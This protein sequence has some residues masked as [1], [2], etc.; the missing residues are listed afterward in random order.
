MR[1]GSTIRPGAAG[2]TECLV[3]VP[4]WN[5]NWQ[6]AYFYDTPLPITPDDRLRITCSYDTTSRDDDVV[7]GEGTQDEMCIDFLYLSL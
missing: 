3:D 2:D 1:Q 5:F 4:S 6:M 7:W